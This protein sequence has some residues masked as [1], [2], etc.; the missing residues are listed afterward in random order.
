MPVDLP[1]LFQAKKFLSINP[2]W[3]ERDSTFL[4]LTCPLDLE[5][6]TV[7]EGFFLRATAMKHRP[8]RTVAFQLVYKPQRR[9]VEGGPFARIEWRPLK[10]HTNKNFGPPHLRLLTI[11][12]SHYHRF[13][14]NWAHSPAQVR[15]GNLYTAE[16]ID[17]DPPN[18]GDLLAF[19]EKEFRIQGVSAIAV[20]PWEA[21]L[22]LSFK[23]DPAS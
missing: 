15:R 10:P 19:V 20:P 6:G 16:P 1:A 8:D 23:D 14:Y 5:D 12:G 11:R 9:N 2:D 7:I 18:Y 13:D 4:S 21:K 22:E 17:P 3:V